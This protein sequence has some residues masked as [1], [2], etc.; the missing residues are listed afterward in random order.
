MMKLIAL[1]ALVF[2][3]PAIAQTRDDPPQI[4]ASDCRHGSLARVYAGTVWLIRGCHDQ[5]SLAFV[6]M[7]GSDAAPCAFTLQYEK[8][9]Y[10]MEGKCSGNQKADDT[11]A[12]EI[13]HLKP[14]EIWRLY[15][16]AQE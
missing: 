9:G 12:V 15:L 5:R 13:G 2:A 16:A 1:A 4:H 10:L 14:P 7:R 6:A 8:G 3:M 11:A